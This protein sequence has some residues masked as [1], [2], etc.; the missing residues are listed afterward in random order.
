MIDEI[1]LFPTK[2]FSMKIEDDLLSSL[3][4]EV[5]ERREDLKR[6][7]WATQQQSCENYI[8]DY[9]NSKK[10]ES[11][12]Q[13]NDI[14][15]SAFLEKELKFDLYKYWTAFYKKYSIHEMHTHKDKILV[16]HNYSGILYLT[17]IGSTQFFSTNPSSFHNTL[18]V[19]SDYGSIV[20][21]PAN[22]PHQVITD[23]FDSNVE[24]CIIAF[25]F[26]LSNNE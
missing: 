20:M 19:N 8:T 22:I 13:V 9:Y 23:N 24:R 17:N 10:Y 26:G 5:Y 18:G 12:D 25:N 3:T 6:L 4:K 14:L 21:F 11:F 16:R 2:F 1:D 7:S 15:K